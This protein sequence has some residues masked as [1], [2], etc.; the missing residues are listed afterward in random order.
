MYELYI[1]GELFP[2]APSKIS[3]KHKNK[4]KT[5]DLINGSEINIVKEQ[6]LREVDF[7]LLLPNTKYPFAQYKNGFIG[8]DTFRKQ[9]TALKASKEPFAFFLIRKRGGNKPTRATYRNKNLYMTCTLEDLEFTDDFD[10]VFDYK[11]K[12]KLKE[13]N[14]MGTAVYNIKKGKKKKKGNGKKRAVSSK[15]RK[16]Q[17]KGTYVVKKGDCLWNIAKKFYGEGKLYTKIYN[18]NKDKIKNPN[19]IYPGQKLVIPK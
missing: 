2:V 13:W 8:G 6:G 14:P 15:K 12:V 1:D 7:E 16:E 4:N 3:V 17:S 10:E 19:L 9:L 11:A 18:A 5:Y